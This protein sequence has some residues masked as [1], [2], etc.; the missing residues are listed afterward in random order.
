[1]GRVK[2][3][4]DGAYHSGHAGPR[5]QAEP[6]APVFSLLMTQQPLLDVRDLRKWFP[7][8][9]GILSRTVG[10]VKAVDGVSFTLAKGETLGL[11]GESGCGKTT[12]GRMI[13]QLLKA[14]SGSVQLR[15]ADGEL[16]PNLCDLSNREMKPYRRRIQMI[17]QDPYSSLNPRMTVG[18]IIGEALTIHDLARGQ[19]KLDRVQQILKDVELLPSY[20]RRFPHEFSGGQRQR[21]GIARALAVEPEVIIADEPVSALDVSI[22]AQIVNLL[23]RLQEERGISFIFVAHDLSVVGH[24]SHRVAVMY[25]GRIVELAP[26]EAIFEDPKHP[27]TRALL[28]SVP[29][30]D[31]RRKLKK[32]H[33]LEGDVPSP[34]NPPPGC[35]F[36]PRCSERFEPCDKI[37][38]K[39]TQL[40]D[41]TCVAC[42]L[43]NVPEGYRLPA[44]FQGRS[45]ADALRGSDSSIGEA[46]AA[47]EAQLAL[48]KSRSLDAAPAGPPPATPGATPTQPGAM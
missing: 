34:V 23:Q 14:T 45:V 7:I 22:Q 10:H 33:L 24:I 2:F 12:T 40:P 48:Q 4:D 44:K 42:H 18:S 5:Q 6:P 46:Q 11:V 37:D 32:R 38:P 43:Y 16:S 26:K 28:R 29:L 17:F 25:L 15:D 41:G 39:L 47:R 3:G 8:K 27:Y 9:A 20:I 36:H 13:I 35:D 31:P 30:P 21:I 19:E 1:M